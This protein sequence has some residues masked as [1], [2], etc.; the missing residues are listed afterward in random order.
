[1]TFCFYKCCCS[2]G[3]IN[4]RGHI[5]VFTWNFYSKNVLDG[6]TS[7]QLNYNLVILY[8]HQKTVCSKWIMALT[9]EDSRTQRLV[10]PATSGPACRALTYDIKVTFRRIIAEGT[11]N[12]PNHTSWWNTSMSQTWLIFTALRFHAYANIHCTKISCL[13]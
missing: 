2:I 11:L 8:Q 7:F 3:G 9:I 6:D 5:L 10:V 1:M 13:C 4:V 12:L